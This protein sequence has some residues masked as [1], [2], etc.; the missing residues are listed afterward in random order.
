MKYVIFIGLMTISINMLKDVELINIT[1][2]TTE[3]EFNQLIIN[4]EEILKYV[5]QSMCSMSVTLQEDD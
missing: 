2:H 3:Y 1:V 5:C 4:M